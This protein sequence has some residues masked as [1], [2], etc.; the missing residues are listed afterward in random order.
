MN[1]PRRLDCAEVTDLAPLFVT[2]AL[3]DEE[4]AAVRAHLAD[5]PEAHDE[6]A[7]LGG[8]AAYLAQL[9]EPLEPPA[10]LEARLMTA[11]QADLAAR[12]RADTDVAPAETP[13]VAPQPIIASTALSSPTLISL[14]AE[15]ARRRRS[16]RR[17][18]LAAAAVVLV[19]ALA[20]TNVLLR[21][22]LSDAHEQARL[23]RDA[24]AAAG[25]PGATVASVSGTDAQPRASGF[26]VLSPDK[27]GF[28]VVDGM[29][30]LPAGQVYEAWTIAGG[31]PQP[32]GVA[33]PT[34]GLVVF[35]LAPTEPV[36]VVALTIE[37]AGGSQTPTMPIQAA[38]KIGG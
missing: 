11:V 5:C 36:Q 19:V 1:V 24:V 32:A 8:T 37:P 34:D 18:L 10:G 20:G 30:P 3:A 33:T 4:A 25:Q 2:G 38:G 29:A 21:G 16:I 31:A 12:T 22:Q 28:L 26:V 23:L 17:F 6:F 7:L 27:S 14:D 15:R 9:P 13:T 35:L